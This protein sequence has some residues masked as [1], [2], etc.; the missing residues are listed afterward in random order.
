[1]PKIYTQQIEDEYDNTGFYIEFIPWVIDAHLHDYSIIDL[2][3]VTEWMGI[4]D[5]HHTKLCHG[6]QNSKSSATNIRLI[7]V[8][9]GC[10]VTLP[11]YKTTIPRYLDVSYVW[12]KTKT[13]LC[14]TKTSRT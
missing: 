8:E 14:T 9:G 1:M 12:G 6:N 11:A 10:I 13:L 7:D 3:L 2:T 4:C 5:N